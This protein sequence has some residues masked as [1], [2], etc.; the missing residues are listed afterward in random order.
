VRRIEFT[1]LSGKT[2][3]AF[4]LLFLS[5][6]L[7]YADAEELKRI[8]FYPNGADDYYFTPLV[9]LKILDSLAVVEQNGEL[10]YLLSLTDLDEGSFLELYK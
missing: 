9:S 5:L 3:T 4:F 2:L 10:Y 8:S 1:K 7:S 6:N